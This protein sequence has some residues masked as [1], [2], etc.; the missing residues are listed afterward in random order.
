MQKQVTQINLVILLILA[1]GEAG[2]SYSQKTASPPSEF[3]GE[4]EDRATLE[5]NSGIHIP[6]SATGVIGYFTGLREITSYLRFQIPASDLEGFLLNTGCTTQLS[7]VD[8]R[9]QLEGFPDRSW[10]APEKAQSYGSCYA[11]TDHDIQH[12]FIEAHWEL[13]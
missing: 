4:S 13:T 10:W 3:E 2:C 12:V 5:G 1:L 9:R 6:S 7:K 8:I 11:S